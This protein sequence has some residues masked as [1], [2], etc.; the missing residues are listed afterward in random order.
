M[1]YISKSCDLSPNSNLM[2]KF[3]KSNIQN[4]FLKNHHDALVYSMAKM[5]KRKEE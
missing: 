1:T 2:N 3:K 4:Q 5:V